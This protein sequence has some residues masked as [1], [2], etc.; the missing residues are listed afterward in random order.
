MF[1][2]LLERMVQG[3]GEAAGSGDDAGAREMIGGIQLSSL[4]GFGMLTEEQLGDLLSRL[5]E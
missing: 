3:M 4:V 1:A 5:N 2:P